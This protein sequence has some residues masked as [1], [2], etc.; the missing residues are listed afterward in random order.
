M[1][2]TINATALLKSIDAIAEAS[3]QRCKDVLKEL[4][5]EK[6]EENDNGA[7]SN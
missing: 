2:E 6:L 1:A 5:V 7:D 4:N 3:I